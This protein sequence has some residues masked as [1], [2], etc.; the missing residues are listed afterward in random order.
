MA[1]LISE[2][3]MASCCFCSLFVRH[4]CL[5]QSITMIF[6]GH[7]YIEFHQTSAADLKV[8]WFSISLNIIIEINFIPVL[9][10][11]HMIIILDSND[12]SLAFVFAVHSGSPIFMLLLSV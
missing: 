4:L 8:G 9:L 2:I 3:E 5:L 7:F 6:V 10:R 12:C 1:F 11:S